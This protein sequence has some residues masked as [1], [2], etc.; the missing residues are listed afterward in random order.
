VFG[1]CCWWRWTFYHFVLGGA[2]DWVNNMSIQTQVLPYQD[3]L[4]LL[5]VHVKSKNPRAVYLI[6]DQPGDS[7]DLFIRKVPDGLKSGAIITED[8]GEVLAKMSLLSDDGYELLPN[9]ELDD[10]RTIVLPA[11]I[12]V[13]VTADMEIINGSKT[14]SGKPDHDYLTA[15]TV[16]RIE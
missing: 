4:R 15:S 13:S 6:L 12:T 8:K 1:N 7:F 5:V 3:N 10:I 16:I 14:K 9:S 11:G 2:T